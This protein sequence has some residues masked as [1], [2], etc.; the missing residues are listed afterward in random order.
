ME[1][2]NNIKNGALRSGYTYAFNEFE[3][4]S[5]ERICARSGV[6]VPL[7][8]KVFDLLMVLVE[9]PNRLLGKDELIERVWRDEFV[10]EGNLARNISTLRKAL[11][12]NGKDHKYIATVQGRGYRFL[13][14]VSKKSPVEFE[15]AA[16]ASALPEIN[17]EI[18]KDEPT[19]RASLRWVLLIVAGLTLLSAAWFGGER[20]LRPDNHIKTLAVLPLRGIDP[21]DNYLGVGIADA[22]IRRISN[23]GQMTVRPTSAVLHYLNQDADTL[24]AARE[25]DADAILEGNVQRT[26][27]RLRISVN[28]LKTSD[29]SS[30]WNESFEMRSDDIF[31]I[32]DEVAA[33]VADKLKV[34]L[35][36]AD[37]S[38][39]GKYPVDQRAYEFYLKGL[40]SLD[41]RGFD[42]DDLQHMLN[43]IDLFQQAIVIEPKYA[44]A[45]GQLAY[46]YVWM[47]LFVQPNERKWADLA[48]Q[49]IALSE[50]LDPNVAEAHIASGLLYWSSYGGYQ[51]E[52]A[53]KELRLAKRLN[54]SYVGDDLCALYGHIGLDEMAA[55]ELNRGLSIDPTS[56]T[57][58]GLTAILPYLRGDA[59]AWFAVNPKRN[60]EERGLAPWYLLHKGSLERAQQIL[61]ERW[62]HSP[63]R[64]DYLMQRSLLLA[65]QGKYSEA[66][67][68]S[69][70]T[71]SVAQHNNENY[72][73]AAYYA[74]CVFAVDGKS[75]DAVKWLRETAN[76]GYPNYGLFARDPF[77]D[78]IRQSPEFIQFLSE[79]KA[80]WERFQ[81]E[82]SDQ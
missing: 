16:S 54:P 15:S 28:L 79:Q 78:R 53:I 23:S 5:A 63:A 12:D 38:N 37:L 36:A 46:S 60:L 62:S 80:Q 34:R 65:L 40:F 20:L 43:T 29:G 7:T 6:S 13:P 73:H 56:Q 39:I 68:L 69:T 66:T 77:L 51:T 31:R 24:A 81:Q 35:N 21:N 58:N 44:M 27:D 41:Q 74:A 72:H 82:F 75:S 2:G 4:D 50:Q 42:S 1:T 61:E 17:S 47:A 3:I 57:L 9:N 49:E 48:Q 25:L 19:S 52:A 67:A 18:R 26:G 76:T 22:V 8:G 14:E 71:M 45:H 55:K 70:S 64:T 59:D 11:G 10:E 30:I 33:Q 32:Q